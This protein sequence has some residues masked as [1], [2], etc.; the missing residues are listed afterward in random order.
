MG[1]PRLHHNGGNVGG[2]GGIAGVVDTL[3]RD[4]VPV[5]LVDAEGSVEVEFDGVPGVKLDLGT[6]GPVTPRNANRARLCIEKDFLRI[7]KV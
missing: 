7:T 4:G 2:L 3:Q 5:L 1:E 6:L